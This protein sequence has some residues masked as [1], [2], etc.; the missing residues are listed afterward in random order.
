MTKRNITLL[1]ATIITFALSDIHAQ[2][3]RDF[4]GAGH[5]QGVSVRSSSSVGMARASNTINGS[6]LDAQN[7]EASRFLFQAGWGGT[8]QEI[9][10]LAATLDF[11]G[12]IDQQMSMSPTLLTPVLWETNTRAKGLSAIENKEHLV[13]TIYSSAMP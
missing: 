6:G 10:D 3:D 1:F 5:D 7:I 4:L 11:E 13:F 8:E 2:S 9:L 12:W